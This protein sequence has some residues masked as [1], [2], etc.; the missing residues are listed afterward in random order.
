MILKFAGIVLR[1]PSLRD[2]LETVNYHKIISC[3]VAMIDLSLSDMTSRSTVSD[4]DAR[5]STLKE[6]IG[7]RNELLSKDEQ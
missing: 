7:V 4:M 5:R 2:S 3:I 1:L 6:L